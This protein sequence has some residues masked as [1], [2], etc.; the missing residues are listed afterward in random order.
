MSCPILQFNSSRR[1]RDL[2]DWAGYFKKLIFHVQRCLPLNTGNILKTSKHG[3]F[4]NQLRCEHTAFLFI[5]FLFFFCRTQDTAVFSC[6]HGGGVGALSDPFLDSSPTRQRAMGPFCP[7]CVA[8]INSWKE[9]LTELLGRSVVRCSWGWLIRL[10][11][12]SWWWRR[13]DDDNDD[14]DNDDDDDGN[15][16]EK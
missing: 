3:K 13:R 16:E 12:R 2:F 8:S 5:A 14:D 11:W 4:A 9:T 1:R 6:S 15:D 7:L 10:W